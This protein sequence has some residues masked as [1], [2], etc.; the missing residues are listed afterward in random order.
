MIEII[1][2]IRRQ[3]MSNETKKGE[4]KKKGFLSFWEKLKIR[5]KILFIMIPVAVIPLII[6]ISFTSAKIYNHLKEQ[7]RA[8]YTAYISQVTKNIN[9]VYGQY[10]RTIVVVILIIIYAVCYLHPE[11]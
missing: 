8:N 7:G 6:I 5:Y 10:A 3:L 11:R 4:T 2:A 1:I 9:F